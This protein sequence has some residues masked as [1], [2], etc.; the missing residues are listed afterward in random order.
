MQVPLPHL[1]AP[2]T[3]QDLTEAWLQAQPADRAVWHPDHPAYPQRWRALHRP[4]QQVWVQGCGVGDWSNDASWH[5]PMLAIVGSRNP[6]P[7]GLLNARQFAKALRGLG[8]CIVSGLALGI[9][10]AAHEGALAVE[11]SPGCAT[12]AFVGTGVDRVYPRRHQ[13]LA[14][15]VASQGLLISEYPLGASARPH[16]FPERNRLIAASVDGVLVVEAALGSGSLITALMALEMGK[17]V[18]AVPGSIHSSLAKGCHAL[19]REGATLVETVSDITQALAQ[20]PWSALAAPAA[21]LVEAGRPSQDL[22]PSPDP[23]GLWPCLQAPV[24]IDALCQTTGHPPEQVLA[25]LSE[26]LLMGRLA[27]LPSGQYQALHAI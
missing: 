15:R 2:P 13:A 3:P 18:L 4:P 12:V 19:L 23:L 10:G 9:D 21:P 17:E 5:G 27:E 26:W 22:C 6:T 11:G 24:S 20:G 25:A 7:Q 16:H 8:V 1:P 14:H